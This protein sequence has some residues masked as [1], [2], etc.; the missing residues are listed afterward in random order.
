M[1]VR[2]LGDGSPPYR[3]LI[4]GTAS[5]GRIWLKMLQSAHGQGRSEAVLP[6]TFIVP[7]LPG[8]GESEL[9]PNLTFDGC[10]EETAAFVTE[11]IRGAEQDHCTARVHIVGHSLGAAVAMHLAPLEWVGSVT[12]VCPATPAF[13]LKTRRV[14]PPGRRPDSIL[15]RRVSGPLAHDPLSLTREDA[16]M[17]REDHQ[18]AAALLEEGLPWPR[19]Y[20]NEASMLQGKRVLV[21][22]GEEDTVVEPAYFHEL[23]NNLRAAGIDVKAV[24][25]PDCGHVPMLERPSELVRVLGEFWNHRS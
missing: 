14:Y 1:K 15:L 20:D 3:L 4:H 18:R 24:S 21:V 16:A 17:L 12:L 6:G 11:F 5:S 22:W 9:P 23:V 7:D 2:V 19:F 25:I 10:V 13:C 8:M